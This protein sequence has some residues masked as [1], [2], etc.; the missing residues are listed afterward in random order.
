[1]P[2]HPELPIGPASRAQGFFSNPKQIILGS[3]V[4]ALVIFLFCLIIAQ[5]NTITTQENTIKTNKDREDGW[6]AVFLCL[7]G[8][9]YYL[10]KQN[11]RLEEKGHMVEEVLNLLRK[12]F[13]G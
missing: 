8:Y 12:S 4:C 7:L 13:P 9:V 1:V 6:T 11:A 2:D 3:G 5:Y 10:S